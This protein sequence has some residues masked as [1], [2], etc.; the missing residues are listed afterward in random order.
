MLSPG[1]EGRTDYR[2]VIYKIRISLQ[3][4]SPKVND[5]QEGASSTAGQHSSQQKRLRGEPMAS[6]A[7]R[8]PVHSPDTVNT[9]TCSRRTTLPS[10]TYSQRRTDCTKPTP[11]APRTIKN[12]LLRSCRLVQQQLR[13]IQGAWTAH[14]AESN[15]SFA[16]GNEW[17]NF[18]V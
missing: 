3:P 8:H 4:R 13:E 17:K 9:R 12:S 10:A 16:D 15:Q 11:I 1:A 5:L 2:L 7:G 18:I 14:E 6:T